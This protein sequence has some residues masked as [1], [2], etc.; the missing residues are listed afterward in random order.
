MPVIL[1]RH[2]VQLELFGEHSENCPELYWIRPV[3]GKLI[4]QWDGRD[5][6]SCTAHIRCIASVWRKLMLCKINNEEASSKSV[7]N[8]WL[9]LRKR[10]R[11]QRNYFFFRIR[12]YK[13]LI[14]KFIQLIATI[15]DEDENFNGFQRKLQRNCFVYQL[16]PL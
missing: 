5:L 11:L 9:M 14:S 6:L 15:I 1:A 12:S 7:K 16:I 13:I 8:R 3:R 10:R 4:L 2:R